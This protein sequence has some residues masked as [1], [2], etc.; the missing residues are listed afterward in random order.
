MRV[1]LS[2]GQRKQIAR[3]AA[4]LAPAARE[5]FINDVTATI[6]VVR[7]VPPFQ[8]SVFMCDSK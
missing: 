5:V 2:D 8:S 4:S 7:G 3:A 1:S 6:E